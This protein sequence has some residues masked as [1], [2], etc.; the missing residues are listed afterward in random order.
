MEYDLQ[1]DIIVT[2]TF[3]E[4]WKD[5]DNFWVTHFLEEAEKLNL[6]ALKEKENYWVVR[7]GNQSIALNSGILTLSLVKSANSGG[8]IG[9][10][11][12]ERLQHKRNLQ[13]FLQE[14]IKV[15]Y[16]KENLVPSIT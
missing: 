8:G 15:Y 1:H 9:Y 14:V 2:S 7:F 12:I 10:I 4:N 5:L 6:E 11:N 13:I 3:S 16:E